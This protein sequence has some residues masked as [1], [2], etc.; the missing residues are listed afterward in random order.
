MKGNRLWLLGSVAAIVAILVV[1]W[2]LG[3]SPRLA[4]ASAAANEQINVDALNSVQTGEI[5]TL[6]DQQE[7][8]EE[9]EDEVDKLRAGIPESALTDTFSQ[10]IADSAAASGATIT[11]V[12]FAEP[13]AWGV[14][15]G[16]ADAPVSESEPG[17]ESPPIPTAAEG[18]YTI[19]VTVELQGEA[20]AVLSVARQLQTGP[21]LFVVSGLS[22]DA[23]QQNTGVITGYLFVIRDPALAPP[24]PTDTPA[25]SDT[26]TPTPTPSP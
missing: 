22:F 7:N 1:G 20:A 12:A 16:P 11:K 21:R 5:A 2:L 6:R 23:N 9:L 8:F 17:T 4:E 19:A 13:G 18:V 3:I 25:P 26:S 24:T 10:A 15:T 14:A